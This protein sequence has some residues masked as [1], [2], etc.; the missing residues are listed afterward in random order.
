ME[1]ATPLRQTRVTV[2]ANRAIVDGLVID[3]ETAVALVRAR[4]EAGEDPAKVVVDAIEIG[5]RV[6]DREQAGAN[7]EFVKTEF[8]KVSREVEV[9]FSDKARVVAEF[10]GKK[11]DEVFHEENGHLSKSLD[12][13]F[14]DG[15]SAAVQH[16]VREVVA[17]VMT[18][19]REDLVRQF[20][21]ADGTN[22]L[23]QFQKMV[24]HNM[25]QGAEQQDAAL[26][27]MHEKLAALELHIA[28][29]HAEKEK[30]SEVAAEADRGTAK[31]RTFEEAVY[32]ALDRISVNQGDD[33][34]AVGD[35]KGTTRRTGDIVV[36][37]EACRGPARGRIVFEAKTA[38][39]TRP[40]ALE[41]LDR[42]LVERNADYAVLVVPTEEKV[43]AK[44]QTLR[45]MNGD[46]LIVCFDPE[47][48]STLSLEVGYSLARA[49]VMMARGEGDGVD[50]A[51]VREAVERA[52]G[53]MGEVQRVKQQL[54]GATTS[55]ENARKI[56]DAMATQVRSQLAHIETLLES[57]EA[58][59]AP[60]A[61]QP[62]LRAAPEAPPPGDLRFAL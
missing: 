15:S 18:K 32:E 39:L 45:E 25:R 30:Q 2:L 48:G 46:K 49:R 42:A 11:V 14:S 10:F 56:V 5:A 22:P 28:K 35:S 59:E 37:L 4:E 60:V 51:A 6:L 53:A 58:P 8:E 38:K 24:V 55:I 36:A 34:D 19:S 16:R 41:E 61:G 31:G 43:P 44:M 17:E 47:D 27:S 52:T 13:H 29:L 9:A 21:S 7:A 57:V 40:K 50:V 20:S 1:A 12:R 26:R 23:A 33:C 54:T 62:A 3:D